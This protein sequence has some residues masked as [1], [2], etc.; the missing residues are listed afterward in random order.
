MKKAFRL[1][2]CT[3]MVLIATTACAF[4]SYPRHLNGDD[5]FVLVD[6]HMGTGWYVDKSSLNVQMYNP[7]QY[8][9]AVNVCAVNDADR[10]NT[11]ISSVRTM[12]FFYNYDLRKMYIERNTGSNDWRYL[13]PDGCWAETGISMPAGE[14][15]F[16]LAYGIKFY[17]LS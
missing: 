9:I 6:A 11:N 5:N 7:P 8:I 1:F 13:D 4:A 10:G 14:E 15:A 16:E 17:H 12:R 3:L 2:L